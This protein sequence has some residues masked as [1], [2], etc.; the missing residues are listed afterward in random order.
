MANVSRVNGFNPLLNLI[1]AS[2]VGQVRTYFLPSTD[3]TAVFIGDLVKADTTG[4]TSAAGGQNK[5]I[6]SVVQAAA[7]NAVLGAVV[8]F[9]INPLNLNTPQYRLASTGRYVMVADDPNLIFEVQTSNGT[10][11]AADVGLNANF[12]VA[13]GSTT[14]GASGMTLD[15]ATVATTATLPLKIVGFSQR[16][17]N[18][19]GNA[20]AK[21]LV[22]LNNHQFNSGTGTAGV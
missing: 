1:G 17:D 10:L 14:T 16:V 20:S 8:G 18:E 9:D 11:T 15:A 3:A 12:A 22:K 4:D 7:G 6:Q 13:A 5:G 2:M 21:V 19:V